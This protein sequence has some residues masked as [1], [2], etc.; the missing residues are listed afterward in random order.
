MDP[1]SQELESYQKE[2]PLEEERYEELANVKLKD[3]LFFAGTGMSVN[4][5]ELL[6]NFFK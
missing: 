6:L 5:P 1:N 2:Q 4:I 3:R